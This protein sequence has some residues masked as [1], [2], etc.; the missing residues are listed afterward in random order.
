M[1]NL[2]CTDT[3]NRVIIARNKKR[4]VTDGSFLVDKRN[5][6]LYRLNEPPAWRKKNTLPGK[7]VFEGKWK[8]NSNYDLELDLAKAEKRQRQGYLA[9][10]GEI[11]SAQ[12]DSLVFQIKSIDK[13]GLLHAQLLKLSGFWQ[14]DEFNQIQFIV[15]R[16]GRPDML[17]LEGAWQ[18]NKNQQVTYTYEKT[19]LKRKT[20]LLRTLT[21]AG[22]WQITGQNKL[23]YIFSSGS[24]SRFDFRAQ[25]ESPSLYPQ[26]GRIKY[27]VGIGVS[28]RRP[29]GAVP[30]KII[31]LYGAWKFRRNL[32]LVFEMNYGKN[33]IHNMEFG[34][35]A[36][37]SKRDKI[38][39]TLK[40]ARTNRPLGI[41]LTFTRKLLKQADAEAFL[42]FSR[43]L[44][45][46]RIEAGLS[47]P[48]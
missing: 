16:E 6:L 45:E 23:S 43:L 22:F 2:Y 44:K 7:M 48:F 33:G 47:L 9:F 28:Q 15:K 37:V 36:A 38:T 42:K 10:N 3:S 19:C 18:A 39:A 13:Q 5:R 24:K 8:L 29:K 14:A 11:I 20:K 46:S 27:R 32:G 4:I 41:S 21:F 40:D 31:C 26:D 1:K 35:E 12:K 30:Y 17:T 34:A 25:L